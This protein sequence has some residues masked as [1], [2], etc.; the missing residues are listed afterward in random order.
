MAAYGWPFLFVDNLVGTMKKH[1][2]KGKGKR[3]C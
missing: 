2:G 1:K 3:G